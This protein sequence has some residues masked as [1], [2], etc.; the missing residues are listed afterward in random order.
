M[1]NDLKIYI[2]TLKDKQDLDEFYHD[3][4]TTGGP[5]HVPLR[6]VELSARRPYSRNTHYK[7]TSDE[8]ELLKQDPRVLNV[9]L[10]RH[11]QTGPSTART[12]EI[13]S[14]LNSQKHQSWHLAR[15]TNQNYVSSYTNGNTSRYAS[16]F[17]KLASSTDRRG[18][19][20]DVLIWDG[21]IQQDHPEWLNYLGNSRLA[22]YNWFQHNAQVAGTTYYASDYNYSRWAGTDDYHA[23]SCASIAA[24]RRHGWAPEANI[25]NIAAPYIYTANWFWDGSQWTRYMPW[26]QC[27][28]YIQA[29]VVNKP[30]NPSYGDKN[31]TIINMSW[32]YFPWGIDTGIPTSTTLT[33]ST[34]AT[35][36]ISQAIINTSVST[37]FGGGYR[38]LPLYY[39]LNGYG[40]SWIDGARISIG[41]LLNTYNLFLYKADQTYGGPSNW[42]LMVPSY[43]VA[44]AA[45]FVDL[46]D[47]YSVVIIGSAGNANTYSI[48]YSYDSVR[49]NQHFQ[50]GANVWYYGSGDTT[51]N[52]AITTHRGPQPA[53]SQ[54]ETLGAGY[55]DVTSSSGAGPICVGAISETDYL[56]WYTNKGP[57]IDVWAPG[58]NILCANEYSGNGPYYDSPSHGQGLFSGTSAACPSVAGIAALWAEERRAN[59][60][61]SAV[62]TAAFRLAIQNGTVSVSNQIISTGSFT[63]LGNIS[64]SPNRI[65][66][67]S[68]SSSFKTVVNPNIVTATEI[69][70][71]FGGSAPINLS[72]YYR[73]GSYVPSSSTN[74]PTSGSINYG[75][76]K[77]ESKSTVAD[78]IFDLISV[79]VSSSYVGQPYT[80]TVRS[81]IA[82]PQNIALNILF[83]NIVLPDTSVGSIAYG[84]LFTL[85]SGTRIATYTA[86]T[87]ANQGTRTVT[88]TLTAVRGT[89]L[90]TKRSSLWQINA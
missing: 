37:G 61:T 35:F 16:I 40:Q 21:H 9:E 22:N 71:E 33:S 4:E 1:S 15:Q 48:N 86:T 6:P 44:I 78:S 69:Q 55:W 26:W 67:P 89:A 85:S 27:V 58:D 68:T 2:V 5:Q 80:I 18:K 10:L 46:A 19:D 62:S 84:G 74:I 49:Y 32:N 36:P 3:M 11:I 83:E 88:V 30:A 14:T 79:D 41:T 34:L 54:Q 45:D 31:P 59:S 82:A 29:W 28:D 25:Y 90:L 63:S 53:G 81:N 8:A 65:A 87:P 76:F 72:E 47:D 7:L 56:S 57:R 42:A 12:G 77:C 50:S 20:I 23:T 13:F 73:G 38:P 51:T 24:G 52:Y 39:Q 70:Q 66:I 75:M 17:A 60:G 43:N 64:D